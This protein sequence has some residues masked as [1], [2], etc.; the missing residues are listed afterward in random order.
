MAY[1][2][3]FLSIHLSQQIPLTSDPA[4]APQFIKIFFHISRPHTIH[5]R[6]T[7]HGRR[8]RNSSACRRRPEDI[9]S[10]DTAGKIRISVHTFPHR[11]GEK[12]QNDPPPICNNLH[13]PW[14]QKWRNRSM[15]WPSPSYLLS[16]AFKTV[17]KS[18]LLKQCEA[19]PF[20][21]TTITTSASFWHIKLYTS[22]ILSFGETLT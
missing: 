21:S 9:H 12:F 20:S 5:S 8:G 13:F 6:H 17:L 16:V 14:R 3:L 22:L 19:F 4:F 2:G 7:S 11:H 15:V 18:V 10:G 1:W